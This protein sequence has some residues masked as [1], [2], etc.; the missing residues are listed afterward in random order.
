MTRA[1]L[2]DARA[3]ING[4]L[5][6]LPG[7]PQRPACTDCGLSR[8]AEARQCASACQFITPAYPQLETQVHGRTRDSERGDELFFGPY[9]SLHRARLKAPLPGAQWTG[10]TTR[11]CEVLLETG[12]VDGVIC[13]GPDPDDRW[14]PLPMLVTTPQDMA[15]ARGMR[16]G[17][18][19]T[20]ALLEPA[21]AAGLKR[22]AFVGVP[23]QVH[24]LRAL[25]A[26]LGFEAI[27]VIGTPCSDNTT[28][29]RFHEFLGVIDPAPDTITYLEFRADYRVELRYEDGR[30][31]LVPFLMLP[32]SKL[33][34]DFFPLTCR[35]CVDY[36]NALADLTVGYM[37]GDGDQ[38]LI[39]RNA[40]G[41]ALVEALGDALAL[42]P[43]TDKG[44]REGAV[45]GFL[46]NLERAAG[47]LPLRAMP[48]W[49][50][51]LAAW[52][53][54]RIG[55]RGL[56][57]A[58][59][60]LEMKALETVVH[61]RRSA[62]RRMARMIPDHVWQLAARYGLVPRQGERASRP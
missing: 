49:A 48:D 56:E 31:R 62:P 25:E 18:A 29:D 2:P 17:F 13:V 44:K 39:V 53:Q 3:R 46:M 35:T 58:R 42:A 16:M 12:A 61:L 41:Q 8:T 30:K 5:V 1:S 27:S 28:T 24:A 23:C 10:I 20:L 11:L 14:K 9:L 54:P 22:I 57:F 50:R 7:G 45:K 43:V 33:G 32:L 47:G 6:P 19:P 55:P 37:G 59:T 38:W 36:T 40:R 60:R 26:Q 51:P 21:R 34:P 15:L 52:L 4:A